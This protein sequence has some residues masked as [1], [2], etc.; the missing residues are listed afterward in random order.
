MSNRELVTNTLPVTLTE[1]GEQSFDLSKLFAGK[2]GKKAKNA[3]DTRATV[4]NTDHPTSRMIEARP[5][6]SNHVNDDNAISLMAAIYINSIASMPRVQPSS[7]LMYR[8][9][10]KV[11][12]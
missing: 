1:K 3:A 11:Y 8:D 12:I 6:L 5:S 7:P 10:K 4:E 2:D 9:W